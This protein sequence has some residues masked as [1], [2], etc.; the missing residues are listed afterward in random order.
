[1]SE[2]SERYAR[3]AEA[4][5]AKIA[6]VPDEAWSNPSP[7]AEWTARVQNSSEATVRIPSIRG[8]IRDRNGVSLVQSPRIANRGRRRCRAGGVDSVFQGRSHV[9]VR[10]RQERVSR[11]A[12]RCNQAGALGPRQRISKTTTRQ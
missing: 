12:A 9:R 6:A 7:C 11:L 8:E 2:I 10:S 4:F 5:A 3:L 1:M